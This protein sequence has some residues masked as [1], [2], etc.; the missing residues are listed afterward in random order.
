MKKK[1]PLQLTD[2]KVRVISQEG[3]CLAGHQ[4]GQEWIVGY[5]TPEGICNAAYAMLYPH[6]R[7]FQRGGQHEYPRG[8]GVLRLACPD[9]WSPVIFELSPLPE[10]AHELPHHAGGNM[11]G[12]P[13]KKTSKGGKP[14]T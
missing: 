11:E 9:G 4:V 5:N 3:E 10:T 12:L 13:L 2:V 8:S 14:G 1:R 6:I 7:V